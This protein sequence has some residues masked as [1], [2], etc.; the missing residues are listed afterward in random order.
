MPYKPSPPPIVNGQHAMAEYVVRELRRLGIAIEDLEQRLSACCDGHSGGDDDMSISSNYLTFTDETG[1]LPGSRRLIAGSNVTL[2]YSATGTV[3][4]NATYPAPPDDISG[5]SYVTFNDDSGDLPNSLRMFAGNNISFSASDAGVRIN[6]GAG[7]GG[8]ITIDDVRAALEA[9]E[10]FRGELNIS[11]WPGVVLD[12]VDGAQRILNGTLMQTAIDYAV[13]HRLKVRVSPGVHQI[14][15]AGGLIIRAVGIDDIS[16]DIV[17]V[18]TAGSTR[19]N[20]TGFTWIAPLNA[21]IHQYASNTPI[22]VVCPVSDTSQFGIDFYGCT[23]HYGQD[24]GSN[25][26][27][28]ALV[29]GPLWLCRFGGIRIANTTTLNKNYMGIENPTCEFFYSNHLYDIKVFK[30]TQYL[31]KI[32]SV[33]TGNLLENIYLSGVTNTGTAGSVVC[34]FYFQHDSFGQA[35]G[36]VVNQLNL[37]WCISPQ[38]MQIAN[39]RGITFNGVHAERCRPTGS[40]AC[41]VLANIADI[42]FNGFMCLDIDWTLATGNP[43]WFRV[44]NDVG[45]LVNGMSYRLNTASYLPMDLYMIYQPDANGWDN[46]PAKLTI[47]NLKLQDTGSVIAQHLKIDRTIDFSDHGALGLQGVQQV[48]SCPEPGSKLRGAEFTRNYASVLYGATVQDAYCKYPGSMS[49][50]QTLGLSMYMGPA[51]SRHAG[52]PVPRGWS[53]G[54]RRSAGTGAGML[55]VM[56]LESG[57]TLTSMVTAAN[58]IRPTFDGTQWVLGGVKGGNPLMVRYA[59][60]SV[61]VQDYDDVLIVDASSSTATVNL[62]GVVR[63][64]T[65]KVKKKDGTANPVIIDG[66]G[67]ETIDGVAQ[68]TLV[69]EYQTVEL[70]GGTAEW[71]II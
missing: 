13:G 59:S 39:I 44:V 12:T 50:T 49:N 69:T 15:L 32:A 38:L 23:L 61:T 42:N 5:L 17:P 10:Y 35:H 53:F 25:S 58:N 55:V 60:G 47:N 18:G 71:H 37:E 36:N 20:P 29:L 43:A 6:A 41:L 63:N 57:V 14:D 4:V 62:P 8:G 1:D 54:L 7:V 46:T 40:T 2:D 51:G 64:R 21:E 27:S 3:A 22:L 56:N 11:L 24:E 33:G 9:D 45:I 19:R 30:S 67:A 48:W 28:R 31:L 16:G 34:P 70:V 26:L 68:R 65:L 52:V 66:S